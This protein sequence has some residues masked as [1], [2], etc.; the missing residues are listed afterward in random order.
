MNS[1]LASRGESIARRARRTS[2]PG[3]LREWVNEV[4]ARQRFG[5]TK[6]GR[7]IK[8]WVGGQG[9]TDLCAGGSRSKRLPHQLSLAPSFSFSLSSILNVTVSDAPC[10]MQHIHCRP[11]CLL[12]LELIP[13]SPREPIG[14]EVSKADH[15]QR[16]QP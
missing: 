4:Q 16:R 5:T 9:E 12:N 3:R 1:E 15:M 2:F 11:T 14:G 10:V 13:A 8:R 7:Q 6:H